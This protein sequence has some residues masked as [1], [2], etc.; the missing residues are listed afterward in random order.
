[1]PDNVSGRPIVLE[2]TPESV[3]APAVN[4]QDFAAPK[5]KKVNLGTIYYRVPAL[6]TLKILDGQDLLLQ[7]RIPVY[8]MG[9]TIEM[10]ATIF[11]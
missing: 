1:M 8:Q 7:T 11:K 5:T 2:L 4:A 9:E 3:P 6:C 10:P